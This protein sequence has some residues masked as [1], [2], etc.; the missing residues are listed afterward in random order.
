[1]IVRAD[2][3]TL[4]IN[5]VRG[6]FDY[7]LYFRPQHNSAQLRDRLAPRCPRPVRAALRTRAGRRAVASDRLLGRGTRGPRGHS[8]PPRG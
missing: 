6:S 5:L 2:R 4:P 1:M 7:A 3:W 8:H